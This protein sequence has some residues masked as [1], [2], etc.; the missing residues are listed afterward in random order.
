MES[1]VDECANVWFGYIEYT[2]H[3][4]MLVFEFR[5]PV[6]VQVD[7]EDF[8]AAHGGHIHLNRVAVWVI[9]LH[10]R[11]LADM[12]ADRLLFEIG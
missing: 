7:A 6:A 1:S 4:A 10:E 3:V 11:V 8:Q 9:N 2:L 12:R 5:F